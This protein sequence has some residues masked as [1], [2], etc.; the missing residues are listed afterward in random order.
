[1]LSHENIEVLTLDDDQ[2]EER[3]GNQRELLET[4]Y[5]NVF[6]ERYQLPQSIEDLKNLAEDFDDC[7]DFIQ[8]IKLM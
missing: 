4:N 6:L 3:V 2:I 8:T 1:M 5:N 7:Q